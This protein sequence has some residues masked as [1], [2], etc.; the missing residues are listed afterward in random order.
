[1][2]IHMHGQTEKKNKHLLLCNAVK[3]ARLHD[4]TPQ[5]IVPFIITAVRKGNL[6]ETVLVTS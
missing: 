2:I 6:S 4:I 3:S 1:M 5:K